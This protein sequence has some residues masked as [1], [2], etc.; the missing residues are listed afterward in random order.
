LAFIKNIHLT[1]RSDQELVALYKQQGDIRVLGELYQRYMD[2]LFAVCLKYLKDAETAKDAVMTIF[3]ELV[4]KLPKHEVIHF[5]GWV[6][7]VTKN[8]CLM[9]LRAK[10]QM[11]LNLD[12]EFM[13][14]TDNLHLNGV[15]EKE[16]NL[17]QLTKCIDTLS[18]DQKQSVQLF[19]LQEKSYKE[20]AGITNMEW[21]KVRSLIQNARRNL[22]NCMEKNT[23]IND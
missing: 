16:E 14:L 20:I 4:S 10:K 5:R 21:N 15:L 19:Y 13:Q 2:L 8:H 12:P 7:T 18:P 23:L 9:Q 17:E 3:E 1:D 11:P 6:Y 22:K